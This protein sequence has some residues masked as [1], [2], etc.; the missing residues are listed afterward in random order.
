MVDITR[1][2]AFVL[3]IAVSVACI[4]GVLWVFNPLGFATSSMA[5]LR[6][7]AATAVTHVVLF[8]FKQDADPAAVDLAC[9]RMMAL[10]DKCLSRNSQYPYI[11]SISG[12][13]DNSKEG[14]QDG[15]THGFV[16]QFANLNDREY[17]VEHDPAHQD[18]KKEIEP[19][20][21][22]VTVL[23]FTNGSF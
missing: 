10:K 2:Q 23:D 9:A 5:N 4:V 8:E 17:Y 20:V 6:P 11:Q 15:L 16:V 21:K 12:G 18:F 1:A 14:L 13:R 7:A 19:L 22:K 3:R